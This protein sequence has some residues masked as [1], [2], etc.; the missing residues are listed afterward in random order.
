MYPAN[1][2]L[3]W[4]DLPLKYKCNISEK[5]NEKTNRTI[6]EGVEKVKQRNMN[7]KISPKPILSLMN[8]FFI[9]K[10]EYPK[11]TAKIILI[12][13]RFINELIPAG[14]NPILLTWMDKAKMPITGYRNQ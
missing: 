6:K 4:D 11:T 8:F 14:M 3:S 2:T 7:N 9:I 10:F 13:N 5:I 1:G 12:K